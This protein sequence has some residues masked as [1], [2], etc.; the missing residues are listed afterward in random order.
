[1]PYFQVPKPSLPLA[2]VL[3]VMLVSLGACSGALQSNH[4]AKAALNTP[5]GHVVIKG[6]PV[7]LS[8]FNVAWFDFARD[9]G[10]GVDEKALR[11]ALQQVKDSGGNS[12]RWWMH[13]DGSQTPEWHTV[14]GVRLVAG[15]GGSLIQDL[16]TALD[17]AAEYDVYI[18][19]SIWSFDMLKDNDYRKPP[20]QDNYRLL[21]E[22]KVLNSYI[23]NALVPMVQALNYHPQLAAWELFNEPENMTES[24]FPQQQGFYG[25]KVPSLKQLQKV[26]AL[27]TA[28]IHQAALD[29]NQVA[30][31]TTGS[32]SMGK[33][34]SDIAGG[35][36]LYRDDRMIA[37]AGGNPL[38]TLDFYAPHYYN[39]E[40]KHGAWS[41]FHHHVDYWQV[42]KPVVIGE[43]HANETLDVLNDPVKAEDLC[44]RLIDN[45]YAGGWSW[46]WNE[47]VE[48]LMHCQER[49]A[50]R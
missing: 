24:W 44:S 21:T 50:I 14:N 40:S 16:K 34:N 19:P 26:Q 31:V 2:C 35:I 39:N 33:Y 13:T 11:K 36:N 42:T 43:F 25:G 10:K 12:L 5:Q 6:K 49:A 7:Y 28:A 48:H 4:G 15:P 1:M 29:I 41:P 20:T 3:L 38:A 23:N 9:F 47:H 46:Q 17:I 32:K 45:G 27:M 22:D 8:G 37:A 30:L 18:V